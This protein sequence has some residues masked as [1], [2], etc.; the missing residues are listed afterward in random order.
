MT[1]AAALREGLQRV[2]GDDL[3]SLFVYGAAM[4]PLP[5]R[6]HLDFDFHTLVRR[7]LDTEACERI[8]DVYG[9][10]AEV[11][12]LGADLDGYFVLLADAARSEPPVHQL[13]RVVRD[14][15]WALHRAHVHAGRYATIVGLDPRD[16]VP[17]PTW[18]EIDIALRAELAFIET[19]PNATAFGVLNGARI[20]ASYAGHDAVLSK[21]DAAQWAAESLP[22]EWH[23][24]VRA[25]VRVYER[26]P[27]SHDAVLLREDWAPF[28]AYVREQ[29]PAT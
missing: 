1:V 13:D 29:L 28:V 12:E 20:L 23:E 7:P 5:A 18:P 27:E 16:I 11:S 19:H 3:A 9:A 6:W 17:V 26:A 22:P 15:A 10:L 8:G 25:A 4:F 24:L 2:L 14:E 21:Y